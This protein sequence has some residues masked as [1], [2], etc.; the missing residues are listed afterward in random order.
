MIELQQIE[1][2]AAA[3]IIREANSLVFLTGAGIST[4]SG[5][6]DYRSLTGI[7]Q[8]IERP[9]YLLSYT[10][11]MREPEKFYEFVKKLYRPLAKPNA[12]HQTIVDLEKKKNV[13]TISQNIDGLHEI[14]GSRQLVEFHG[15]LYHCHCLKCG[16]VVTWKE[17][18]YCDRHKN[19]NGQIRPNIVLYEEA[20]SEKTIE[21]ADTAVSETELIVIVG[22]SF[23]VHPFCNLLHSASKTATILVVN[24]P[25]IHIEQPYYFLMENALT[26]F[27]NIKIEG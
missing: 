7:Y 5:I 15:S 18:L 25:P 12:I 23:Q 4:P 8:G 14:A 19:C 11:L 22:T 6:P 9:E 24:Q 13:W 10:C 20:L 26:I 1:R 21:Q 3:R 27:K 16:S 2:T 17:Y